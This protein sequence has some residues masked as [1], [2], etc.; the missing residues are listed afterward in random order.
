M[1]DLKALSEAATLLPCPFCGGDP[2]WG[3]RLASGKRYVLCDT[4]ECRMAITSAYNTKSE[5]ITAWNTRSGQ[6]VEAPV[7]QDIETAPKTEKKGPEGLF[8]IGNKY[9]TK[10]VFYQKAGV[11]SEPECGDLW[12]TPDLEWTCSI[13]D[14]T[15]THW[16]VND[17]PTPTETE[18]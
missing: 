1:T 4:D 6:L 16:R 5:A 13:D 3:A 17:V 8:I 14:C 10:T 9:W 2:K 15:A 12:C 11:I 7:W 18:T